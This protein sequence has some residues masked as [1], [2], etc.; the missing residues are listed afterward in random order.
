MKK[1]PSTA[2][3]KAKQATQSAQAGSL[4]ITARTLREWKAAG[5]SD[6][7]IEQRAALRKLAD[8]SPLA[9]AKLRKLEAEA[10]LREVQVATARREMISMKLVLE[11][12]ARI[13]AILKAA[14]NRLAANLPAELEGMAPGSMREI[15]REHCDSL[16]QN[17]YDDQIDPDEI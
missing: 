15:I 5:L 13:G 12:Q 1:S 7:Q 2:N 16:L 4:G 17:I 11:N 10:D 8:S 14:L 6:K 3:R 9:Q